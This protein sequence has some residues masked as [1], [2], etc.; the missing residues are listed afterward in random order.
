MK[1]GTINISLGRRD[2]RA[3][4]GE[5][6]KKGRR[7]RFF[8]VVYSCGSL[9]FIIHNRNQVVCRASWARAGGDWPSYH[10]SRHWRGHPPCPPHSLSTSSPFHHT[11]SPILGCGIVQNVCTPSVTAQK[12]IALLILPDVSAGYPS[13]F[14][15]ASLAQHPQKIAAGQH[16]IWMVVRNPESELS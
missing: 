8:G 9:L 2:G 13:I 6:S 5:I 12:G 11:I 3:C 14:L 7:N 16:I 4:S 1:E 10:N 15:P